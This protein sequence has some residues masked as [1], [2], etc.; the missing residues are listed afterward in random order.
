MSVASQEIRVG[1]L[2]RGDDDYLYLVL[3]VTPQWIYAR[4]PN[5]KRSGST[6]QIRREWFAQ[7]GWRMVRD[8]D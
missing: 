5:A 8:A 7:D 3:K 1:Q 4:H 6:L 2:W